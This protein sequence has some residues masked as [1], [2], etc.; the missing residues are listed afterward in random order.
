M[1]DSKQLAKIEREALKEAAKIQRLLNSKE[2]KAFLMDLM[3]E[4]GIHR[5]MFRHDSAHFTHVR[6]GHLEVLAYINSV[7]EVDTLEV[8]PNE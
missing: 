6:A 5:S 3:D 8:D 7:L 4:F 1:A 2:G